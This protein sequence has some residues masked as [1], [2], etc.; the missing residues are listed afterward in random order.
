MAGGH[1]SRIRW[2]E[3][4]NCLSL[5]RLDAQHSATSSPQRLDKQLCG[6]QSATIHP[7]VEVTLAERQVV[8]VTSY[9]TTFYTVTWSS[10]SSTVTSIA[11]IQSSEST[12][13]GAVS[14][15][16]PK[17]S[18]LSS[19]T[20]TRSTSQISSIAESLPMSTGNIIQPT[21]MP[22]PSLTSSTFNSTST[23]TQ[24]VV[25][26]NP[27]V[28]SQTTTT[29]TS[30]STSS[31]AIQS[32][33]SFTSSDSGISQQSTLESSISVI[34]PS[35]TSVTSL[36]PGQT[37]ATGAITSSHTKR[38]ILP[39]IIGIFVGVLL[40]TA[41]MWWARKRIRHR[42]TASG[43]KSDRLDYAHLASAYYISGTD[44]YESLRNS[45]SYHGGGLSTH[46]DTS[47]VSLPHFLG[48][49]SC[50]IPRMPQQVLIVPP[51][52]DL[53][54]PTP[55]QESWATRM[56]RMSSA[57]IPEQPLPSPLSPASLT[58][59]LDANWPVVSSTRLAQG[60]APAPRR[61]LMVIEQGR[62]G[63]PPRDQAQG[64]AQE[65]AS[66]TLSMWARISPGT[67]PDPR[68]RRPTE[69]GGVRL[70]GG[71]PGVE[72]VSH[73]APVYETMTISSSV[74][75]NRTP[76]PPYARYSDT[77]TDGSQVQR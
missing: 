26:P 16:M 44:K 32:S 15:S 34:S 29:L 27:S 66:R 59:L 63:G 55:T 41:A 64:R 47:R 2:P 12:N 62:E 75:S 18:S 14:S 20:S 28:T 40:V 73:D 21:Q 30:S 37:P 65:R 22:S 35:S 6:H 76:P 23:S 25:L 38:N 67:L 45:A 10:T 49:L 31:S 71:P 9:T 42:R 1:D 51:Y 56:S 60:W 7:A 68:T 8:T 3:H 19:L 48:P 36:R 74:R 69:D 46:V 13:P 50:D 43:P 77:S 24:R 52:P 4:C 57:S 33:T 61:S 54:L 11:P 70:A 17:I 5:A 39:I 72:F 58:S 53:L